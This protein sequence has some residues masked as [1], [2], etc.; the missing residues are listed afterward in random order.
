MHGICVAKI[1][2]FRDTTRCCLTDTCVLEAPAVFLFRAEECRC[3]ISYIHPFR[4]ADSVAILRYQLYFCYTPADSAQLSQNPFLRLN[5]SF[6]FGNIK[7]ITHERYDSLFS[8]ATL[9]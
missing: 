7:G 5:T 8:A 3:R 4:M 6:F 2:F 9:L 1:L